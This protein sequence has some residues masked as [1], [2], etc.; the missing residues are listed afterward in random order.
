MKPVLLYN[1]QTWG[2]TKSDENNLD[3]FH[4]KQLRIV[5]HIKYPNI[6]SNKNI[7]E[8]TD[9]TPLSLTILKSRWMFLGH[10]LRLH[11]DTPARKSMKYYFTTSYS[12]GF[13]G[14]QRITLPITI[15][16]DLKRANQFRPIHTK[17]LVKSFNN[18]SDLNR[19]TEIASDRILWKELCKEVYEAAQAERL[20]NL[21]A[22]VL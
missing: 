7:Y 22:E 3:S 18:T 9:E 15:N 5:L 19:L 12:K 11:E 21:E 6:V 16:R 20:Q 10:V 2:L 17:Y 14:T 13:R 4:R 8:I 1:S